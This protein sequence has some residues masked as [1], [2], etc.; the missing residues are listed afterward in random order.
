ML[1]LPPESSI[2]HIPEA[3]LL[4]PPNLDY[5]LWV[6]ILPHP[7]NPPRTTSCLNNETLNLIN[8]LAYKT[9]PEETLNS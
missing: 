9:L 1:Q 6:F 2:I 7:S 5:S 4:K 8:E 3:H